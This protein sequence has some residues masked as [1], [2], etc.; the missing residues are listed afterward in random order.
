MKTRRRS[1]ARQESAVRLR[2]GEGRRGSTVLRGMRVAGTVL[3]AIAAHGSV[4]A[5]GELRPPGPPGPTMYSLREIYE[6]VDA[7][8]TDAMVITNI[9]SGLR[10]FSDLDGIMRDT[11]DNTIVLTNVVSRMDFEP[12]SHLPEQIACLTNALGGVDWQD[13]IEIRG[14]VER[15][16]ARTHAITNDIAELMWHMR[17]VVT[18]TDAMV[19]S[20]ARIENC[21]SA[22][23]NLLT[24]MAADL[25]ATR[26]TVEENNAMLRE[27]TDPP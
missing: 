8:R 12:L 24:A 7:V 10:G 20:L 11:L 14:A 2:N 4:L 19:D 13:V 3:L 21:T 18:N 25:E 1:A 6:Q 22:L 15:I 23:T 27:L 5:Q 26:I 9:L 16:D 17:V